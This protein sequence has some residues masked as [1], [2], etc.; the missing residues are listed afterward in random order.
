ML[1]SANNEILTRVGPGTAAGKQ[2]E[3]VDQVEEALR[4]HVPVTCA[5]STGVP[6]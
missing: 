6:K 5:P 3:R 1:N 4:I 2:F